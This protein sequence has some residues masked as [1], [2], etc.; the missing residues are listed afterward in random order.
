MKTMIVAA[1]VVSLS[2]VSSSCGPTSTVTRGAV[3][4]KME[5]E[6]HINLGRADGIEVG[7]TLVATQP[8]GS[9]RG[10]IRHIPVGKVVVLRVLDEHHAA[11]KSIAGAINEG[12]EVEVEVRHE[13]KSQVQ[14]QQSTQQ[15]H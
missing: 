15:N 2:L 6:S 8:Q 3:L 7:D 11:V 12:D 13:R 4:M 5:Q 10:R 9:S 14:D 1:A